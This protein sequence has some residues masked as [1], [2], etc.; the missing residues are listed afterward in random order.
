[1]KEGIK[2]F[3][4]RRAMDIDGLGDKI[5][6]MLVDLKLVENVADLYT[7]EYEDIIALEGFAEKSARNLLESIAA[8]RA[9]ELPR[10]IFALGIP[11]V[12]ET[13]ATQLAHHFGRLEALRSAD[14]SELQ[15][16][17]D[18]GPIVAESIVE[19]FANPT[20]QRVIQQLFDLGVSYEEIT[21]RADIDKDELPLAGLTIV[22]TGALDSLSRN[23]AKNQLQALGAKVTGSV[24]SNTDL[25]VAGADAGSKADK[26][27]ALGIPIVGEDSLRAMLTGEKPQL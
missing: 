19:F 17:P 10:L 9:T 12:G 4:A 26:A 11:Q 7:L 1:M 3:V 2:H 8:S 22:L 16:I 20:N 6:E 15:S 21:P 14:A 24:S 13:T 27:E 5:V 18:I 23:E 25:V